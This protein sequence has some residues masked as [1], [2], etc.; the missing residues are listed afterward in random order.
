[1]KWVSENRTPFLAAATQGMVEAIAKDAQRREKA[2][3]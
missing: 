3:S 1:M 2:A